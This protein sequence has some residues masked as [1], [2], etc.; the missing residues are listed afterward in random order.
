M[1]FQKDHPIWDKVFKKI[2]KTTS[3]YV[4]G[5]AIDQTLQESEYPIIVL[6]RVAGQYVCSNSNQICFTPVESSWNP[7]RPFLQFLNCYY[8][9]IILIILVFMIIIIVERVNHFNIMKFGL[10]TFIPGMPPPASSQ[11][12][13]T[14]HPV[15]TSKKNKKTK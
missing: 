15:K 13:Q 11:Q 10:S 12:P 3:K 6:D 14:I 1:A 4:V 5:Q 9:K 7:I 8:K 2:E